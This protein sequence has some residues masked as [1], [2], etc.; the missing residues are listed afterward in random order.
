MNPILLDMIRRMTSTKFFAA[1]GGYVLVML[2]G[3]GV[4]EF[5]PEVLAIG[6]S[7]MLAYIGANVAQKAVYAY[8]GRPEAATLTEAETADEV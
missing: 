3:L 6:A 2:D 1:V 8:E 7:A 4:A 5:S